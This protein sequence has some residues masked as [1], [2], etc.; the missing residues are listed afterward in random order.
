MHNQL[1][2]LD[3]ARSPQSQE[4]GITRACANKKNS[5]GLC[6][7]ADI[8]TSAQNRQREWIAIVVANLLRQYVTRQSAL[9]T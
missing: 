9:F 5:S 8:G 1:S 4:I 7:G 2:A 6:H 3:Q